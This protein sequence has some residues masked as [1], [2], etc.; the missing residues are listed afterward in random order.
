MFRILNE[1]SSKKRILCIFYADSNLEAHFGIFF[2]TNILH[3]H[4]F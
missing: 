2:C 3:G 1:P 4:D